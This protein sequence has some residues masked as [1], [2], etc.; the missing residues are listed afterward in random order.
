MRTSGHQ[1]MDIGTVLAD[2]SLCGRVT[3]GPHDIMSCSTG[4]L[5]V[6][7][8]ACLDSWSSDCVSRVAV[9]LL[10]CLPP[11]GVPELVYC[12]STNTSFL[13]L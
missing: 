5:R 7:V 2:L 11:R 4:H 1:L 9:Y 6:Y 3:M 12:W 13:S 10:C 8:A